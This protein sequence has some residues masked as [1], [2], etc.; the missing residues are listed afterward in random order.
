MPVALPSSI[1]PLRAAKEEEEVTYNSSSLGK[2]CRLKVTSNRDMVTSMGESHLPPVAMI[3][4]G[5][6][7]ALRRGHAL[8]ASAKVDM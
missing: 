3:P 2:H 4:G 7:Q 8:Q 5:V 1:R 6:G